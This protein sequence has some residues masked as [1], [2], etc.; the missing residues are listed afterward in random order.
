MARAGMQQQ[1]DTQRTM[2][3]LAS[4]ERVNTQD[5]Q[6]A[7]TIAEAETLSEE[8]INVETGTGINPNPSN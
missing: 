7:L 4:R 2:A 1:A 8:K 6:T 5:N 3:E